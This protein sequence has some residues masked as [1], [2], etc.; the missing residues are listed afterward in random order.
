MHVPEEGDF[1]EVEFSWRFWVTSLVDIRLFPFCLTPAE[2]YSVYEQQR[3]SDLVEV[4]AGRKSFLNM[5]STRAAKNEEN[6]EDHLAWDLLL[7][8]DPKKSS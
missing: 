4:S 6:N 1:I 5:Y 8:Q 7:W 2:I 3:T